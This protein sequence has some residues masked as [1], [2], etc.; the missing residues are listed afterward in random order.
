MT[1]EQRYS[2]NHAE[3]NSPDSSLAANSARSGE[4]KAALAVS[5]WT[6]AVRLHN[7]NIKMTVVSPNE[8]HPNINS[9]SQCIFDPLSDAGASAV[10]N[11]MKNG[12]PWEQC[13]CFR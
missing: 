2:A 7:Q 11:Y 1:R 8:I 10:P 6:A 13:K 5:L 3:R 4:S 12:V 9:W